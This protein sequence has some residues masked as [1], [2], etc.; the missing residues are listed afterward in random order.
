MSEEESIAEYF[1][2]VDEVTNMVKGLCEE[3]KEDVIVQ[4]VLRS[5]PMIFNVR[6]SIKEMV[7]LKNF[8]MDQFLGTLTTYEMRVGK[9]KTKPKEASFKV[10]RKVKEYDD[11]QKCSNYESN[12]ELTHFTTKLK[13]GS[14]KYKGNL[15]LY[16]K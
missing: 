14:K 7:D 8:K 12:P 11:H 6:V 13:Y 15:K 5:L 1:H 3:V 10:F 2:K 4:K 16:L 9:E